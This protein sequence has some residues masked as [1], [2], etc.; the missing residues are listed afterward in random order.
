MPRKPYAS[1]LGALKLTTV[2]NEIEAEV[3]C[4]LLREHGIP[5]AHQ[6]SNFSAAIG[7]GAF[8][9][10]PWEVFVAEEDLEAARRLLGT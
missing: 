8:M 6:R 7:E 4:G 10:G 5:C 2:S 3:V 1:R 9:A